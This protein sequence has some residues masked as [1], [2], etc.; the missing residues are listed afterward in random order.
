MAQIRQHPRSDESLFDR[1]HGSG[2]Q[3]HV[4]DGL[5]HHLTREVKSLRQ[6]NRLFTYRYKRLSVCSLE[7]SLMTTSTPTGIWYQEAAATENRL[8]QLLAS[9]RHQKAELLNGRVA[10]LGFVIG[11]LTEAI[12][13]Q[14]IF[15]QITF[16]IF[17]CS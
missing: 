13:G 6:A 17:G 5:L 15:G 12:T 4:S 7:P 10:M 16:G 14:G 8:E 3:I 2:V 1:A 9:E 11:L